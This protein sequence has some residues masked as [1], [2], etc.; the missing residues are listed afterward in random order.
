MRRH[1]KSEQI[2][3]KMSGSYLTPDAFFGALI[4][5]QGVIVAG[6]DLAYP[7]VLCTLYPL[8]RSACRSDAAN[9]LK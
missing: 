4:D 6:R 8:V 1:R 3:K 2:E 9:T 7:V 5:R